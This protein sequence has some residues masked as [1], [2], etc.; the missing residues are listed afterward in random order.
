MTHAAAAIGVQPP[1]QSISPGLG[2]IQ[3]VVPSGRKK[4]RTVRR[5]L[6]VGSR[7]QLRGVGSS[8]LVEIPIQHRQG[9]TDKLDGI[10]GARP[11][12]GDGDGVGSRIRG[13]RGGRGHHW[14]DLQSR[15]SCDQPDIPDGESGVA[16]AI[17]PGL[18]LGDGAEV[19]LV[20]RHRH[21]Q[22]HGVVIIR[23]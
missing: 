18:V 15:V 4:H 3:G 12:R 23:I 14:D 19:R 10:I 6:G 7:R 22:R 21:F 9:S 1:S 5:I 13:R 17:A 11:P 20:D 8:I 16:G 2:H